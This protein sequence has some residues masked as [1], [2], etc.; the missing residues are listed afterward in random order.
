MKNPEIKNLDK[1]AKRILKAVKKKER[2][3]I[4]G[5]SDLDGS[6]S[7][8]ILEE[9]IKNLG[10]E[11]T[12]VYFPDRESE[13]YGITKTALFNLKKFTPCVLISVDLGIGNW[14]EVNIANKMKF[15]IIIIDHH[16]ILEKIPKAKIIVDPKQKGDK[17]PFKQLATAGL[18]FKL[19]ELLFK[20]NMEESLRKNFLEL[21]AMATIADM[22]PKT[23]D[24]SVIISEGLNYLKTT[25]RPGIQALFDID[26]LKYLDLVQRVYKANSLLN[27]R[28]VE[29]NLPASYR[30]LAARTKEEADVLA[31]KL[32]LKGADRKE[33]IQKILDELEVKFSG[34]N[35]PVVFDGR[36][37]KE[38]DIALLG[39]AA[40]ISAQRYKKPVFLFTKGKD[41]SLG[42]ARS[43]SGFNLVLAMKGFSKKLL[44][45]GGHPQAAGF[46]IKNGDLKA[47]KR[48]LIK[49]FENK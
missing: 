18:V 26:E 44:S 7:V 46:R 41:F 40:S 6:A 21:T 24:N 3:I 8:I 49:Y 29:N 33:K 12:Q 4:Y 47:F 38:W 37:N 15:E 23:D 10:G 5:D 19:T 35:E 14:K 17:Y 42:S 28:D 11:N 30:I 34:K 48:H 1:A 16:E 20:N 27:V 2:I 25:W 36:S 31:K 13:G 43:P 39:V 22:M 45:Y 9:A 32:Y